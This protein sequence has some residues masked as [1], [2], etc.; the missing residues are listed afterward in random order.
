METANELRVCIDVGCN[1]HHV[2]I[3]LPSGEILD[4]FEIAHNSQGFEQ[5]FESVENRASEHGLTVSVAMESFNGHARPLDQLI[6]SRGWNLWNINNHK[7]ANFKKIFP[8][9]AKTDKID[10]RRMLDLF[11]M[12]DRLPMSKTTMCKVEPTPE[13]NNKLK[14]LTRRRSSLVKEK[15]AIVCRM[16]SDIRA[17]APGLLS[18]TGRTDNLWFLRFLSCREDFS[19]LPRLQKNS[20]LKINGVG[21]KYAEN[22]M[23]WQK[24]ATL[25]DD[26]EWVGS[27]IYQDAKRILELLNSISLLESEIATLIESSEIALRV[28]TIPGFGPISSAEL[29]GEIGAISRFETEASL[30]LYCG[31]A[32]LDNS[33]GI[34]EGTKT[35]IHVNKHIKKAMMIAVA[36]HIEICDESKI[37]YDK[38]RKEGKK[39]N[40][41]VR[42]LGRH[43]IRVIFSMLVHSRDYVPRGASNQ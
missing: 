41:A 15:T 20:L 11:A 14:R 5:F 4:E 21:K 29:A 42:A 8:G 35:S 38:K 33:S 40:Q 30:A 32:V 43:M 22:I 19:K 23:R 9:P 17:C 3:G 1:S 16:Q 27:M 13:I 10:V 36:R 31:M 26:V 25:S 7:L 39:H 2:G 18:I 12:H 28:K 37:Y 24:N 6:L 34:Y